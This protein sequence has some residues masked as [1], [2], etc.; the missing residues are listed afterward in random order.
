MKKILVTLGATA[1]LLLTP[2]VFADDAAQNEAPAQEV[3]QQQT[4]TIAQNL[5]E[6]KENLKDFAKTGSDKFNQTLSDTYNQMSQTIAEIKDQKG[7]ELQKALD[8]I[9]LKIEEYKKVGSK[10]QEK[11]RKTIIENLEKLNKKID[12]YNKDKA[13]S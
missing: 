10:Q 11:M 5:E 8:N 4:K 3:A 12:E 7:Q 2:N 13:N 6:L 9:N 1:T